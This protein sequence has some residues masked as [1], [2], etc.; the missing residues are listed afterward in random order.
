MDNV[1][2]YTATAGPDRGI[3]VFVPHEHD[4]TNGEFA[5]VCLVYTNGHPPDVLDAPAEVRS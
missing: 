4:D 1:N 3:N 5:E 2:A